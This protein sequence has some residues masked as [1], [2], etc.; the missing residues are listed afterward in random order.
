V[1]TATEIT[2]GIMSQFGVLMFVLA[3]M[4]VVMGLVGA[5]VLSGTLSLSVLERRREIGVMRAIGAAD[6]AIGRLFIGEGLLLGWLS[7]LVAWPLSIPAG[8]FMVQALSKVIGMS[9]V[10]HYTFMGAFYWLGII[11]LLSVWASWLP[12]RNAMRV[13]VRES[14]AYQ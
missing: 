4:A 12:A 1:V 13:S 9:L 3:A 6:G 10:F 5:I 7:W 2:D 8:W 14:L 11:S